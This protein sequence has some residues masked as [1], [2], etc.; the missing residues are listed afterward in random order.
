M[1]QN[2]PPERRLSD[3]DAMLDAIL[4]DEG[5]SSPSRRGT[6][7]LASAAGISVLALGLGLA[8]LQG[9]DASVDLAPAQSPSASAPSG[10]PT[11][12][13][14]PDPTASSAPT[15]P[16]PEQPP[17]TSHKPFPARTT[18]PGQINTYGEADY[19]VEPGR[20]GDTMPDPADIGP[21]YVEHGGEVRTLGD[22]QM[23]VASYG[24]SYSMYL[25]GIRTNYAAVIA[26]V[27]AGGEAVSVPLGGWRLTTE[28][29]VY[30][31]SEPEVAS[32]LPDEIRPG[33]CWSASIGF[34][35]HHEE[36][37]IEY[38][39]TDLQNGESATWPIN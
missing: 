33:D 1:N 25:P 27:P 2:L 16:A 38:S 24:P 39:Y 31:A 15:T 10:T 13:A 35:Y 4:A 32:P 17:P 36:E 20:Y 26:C 28:G 12:P 19:P 30:A 22:L 34:P 5:E 8:G 23:L 6:V 18:P 29:G 7:V 9:R 3:P 14:S 37:L 11:S 21:G